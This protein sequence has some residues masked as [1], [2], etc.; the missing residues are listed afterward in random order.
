MLTL[1]GLFFFFFFRYVRISFNKFEY[2]AGSGDFRH[3]SFHQITSIGAIDS[4]FSI[5]T[6]FF[7]LLSKKGKRL[8]KPSHQPPGNLPQDRFPLTTDKGDCDGFI[9]C[10]TSKESS[11]FAIDGGAPPNTIP[12]PILPL[13]F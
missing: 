10:Q 7:V 4:E 11:P 3:L 9:K 12:T 6:A 5:K 1:L 13:A 8:G 2:R